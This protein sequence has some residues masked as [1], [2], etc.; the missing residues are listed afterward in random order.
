M[1]RLRT[2]KNSSGHK[3]RQSNHFKST[4]SSQSTLSNSSNSSAHLIDSINRSLRQKDKNY[5]NVIEQ[6]TQLAWRPIINE[7]RNSKRSINRLSSRSKKLKNRFAKPPIDVLP[8]PRNLFKSKDCFSDKINYEK[9]DFNHNHL[10]HLKQ[11]N[12]TTVNDQLNGQFNQLNR[13][14]NHFKAINGHYNDQQINFSS[15]FS[16]NDDSLMDKNVPTAVQSRLFSLNAIND[17]EVPN[18]ET[19]QFERIQSKSNIINLSE[20]S[21]IIKNRQQ[22]SYRK[23]AAE[24]SNNAEDSNDEIYGLCTSSSKSSSNA[25]DQFVDLSSEIDTSLNSDNQY[26]KESSQTIQS[27]QNRLNRLK[28]K[29][30]EVKQACKK[31]KIPLNCR[32]EIESA[33]D[34]ATRIPQMI[35]SK[36]IKLNSELDSDCLDRSINNKLLN[37]KLPN[38]KMMNNRFR[39]NS[40]SISKYELFKKLDKNP[41]SKLLELFEPY[42]EEREE[43]A[44]ELNRIL[45]SHQLPFGHVQNQQTELNYS[46]QDSSKQQKHDQM[47]SEFNKYNQAKNSNQLNYSNHHQLLKQQQAAIKQQQRR[48][49]ASIKKEDTNQNQSIKTSHD[50]L[51]QQPQF[52]N[53]KQQ[54]HQITTQ[55][56]HPFNLQHQI[57]LQANLNNLAFFKQTETQRHFLVTFKHY[58][59]EK[60]KWAF[61]VLCCVCLIHSLQFVFQIEHLFIIDS[62]VYFNSSLTL[63]GMFKFSKKKI[64]NNF[65][66]LNTT[67]IFKYIT[68]LSSTCTSILSYD[69]Y[70]KRVHTLKYLKNRKLITYKSM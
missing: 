23:T 28:E 57:N 29:R 37:D 42:E 58:Y 3:R 34:E 48:Q 25:R 66:M 13:T 6:S 21:L 45:N 61:I 44:N 9:N 53:D 16:S 22:A 17:F 47:H 20:N 62:S 51:N 18:F 2:I 1:T 27:R 52:L 43:E 56:L 38:A 54:Q 49:S 69:F 4:Q 65:L 55:F 68:S 31:K 50:L 36:S 5:L 40:E 60:C 63:S 39:S 19:N 64:I 26:N 67:N 41:V 14:N 24:N 10:K 32:S 46:S 7:L 11:Q 8:T 35:I 12:V 33:Y 15:A 70:V 59:P 30:K